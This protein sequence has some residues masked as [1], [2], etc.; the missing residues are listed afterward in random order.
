MAPKSV[1]ELF[2]KSYSGNYFTFTVVRHPFDRLVSAYRDRIMKGCTDQS[3][4]F[5]PQ[6]ISLTRKRS[7]MLGT[8]RLFEE[9]TGCIKVFPT[10]QEFIHFIV[11]KPD[12]HDVHWM[13]YNK[14]IFCLIYKSNN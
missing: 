1:Q 10:F 3:K 7:V 9:N 12:L 4:Y 6:I 5:V 13:S 2:E 11:E 14:V 8:S